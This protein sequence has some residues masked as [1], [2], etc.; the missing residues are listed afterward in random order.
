MKPIDV[1][2]ITIN[3]VDERFPEGHGMRNAATTMLQFLNASFLNCLP[4][5]KKLGL[6]DNPNIF[7]NAEYVEGTTNVTSYANNFLALHGINEFEQVTP[8]RRASKEIKYSKVTLDKFAEKVKP[9]AEIMEFD[10][11]TSIPSIVNGM[12]NFNN[13]LQQPFR[14]VYGENNEETK[15]L[16]AW[17]SSAKNP[18]STMY[19][20]IDGKKVGALNQGC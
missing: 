20:T 6:L 19:V 14:V 17:L 12:P 16:E 8:K 13:V 5:L 1:E 7:L 15:P 11:V 10:V 4:E 9:Q 3:R 2:G 18:Y